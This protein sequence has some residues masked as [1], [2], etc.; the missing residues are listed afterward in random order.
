MRVRS[1]VSGL[2]AA[3][4]LLGLE[5]SDAPL[6]AQPQTWPKEDFNPQPADGDFTIPLPCGGSMTFRRVYTGA[7][8]TNVAQIMN[9]R[10]FFMGWAGAK[11]TAYLDYS[12]IAYINGSLTDAARKDRFYYL[13]KYEVTA[14][15]YAAVMQEPC[16]AYNAE[17]AIPANDITWFDAVQF[18]RRLTEW[19]Y[20]THASAL[21]N[22]GGS[23]S[24]LRL[25]TEVE[26][27]FAA[28]GGM[29]VSPLERLDKMFPVSGDVSDYV[30]HSG[31]GSADGRLNFI[32]LKKPNPLG[33]Y[34][35]LGNVEEFV[36]EP[37]HMNGV[38]RPHGQTGGFVVRGGSF[39][40][41]K[42]DLR[43]SLRQEYSYFNQ[44]LKGATARKTFGFRLA[45][46]APVLAD[47]SRA[48]ELQ[49]AWQ[50]ARQ[51]RA[52]LPEDPAASLKKLAEQTVEVGTK[53]RLNAIAQLIETDNRARNEIEGRALKSLVLNGALLVRALKGSA[54]GID[55]AELLLGK[56]PNK[57]SEAY[58]K[59]ERIK[60]TT[61]GE[62]REYSDI[63]GEVLLR[64]SK[65]FKRQQQSEQVNVLVNELN[66]QKRE[67]L[68][69]FVRQFHEEA[70]GYAVDPSQP[71]LKLLQN[72]VGK[73]PWLAN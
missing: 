29:A 39:E 13:G 21:P 3:L 63:Y 5:A 53:S 40:T 56:L 6:R 60:G 58:G 28:R 69:P 27:E 4:A 15:Q 54:E 64:V 20:K 55:N 12:S 73:K 57:Q 11:E 30:W 46:A 62:F 44:Q 35:M 45:I 37:F 17:A 16:P 22:E 14:M 42:T 31:A 61:L 67:Q 48:T 18:S 7:Q 26:W 59:I 33:L 1:V 71:R 50:A 10:Q 23:K 65:D 25:P 49:K 43:T 24:F 68:V 34:D 47:L 51:S 70:N 19:L 32:G 52:E 41:S 2:V 9:D 8:G 72:L 38:G 36:L 66:A